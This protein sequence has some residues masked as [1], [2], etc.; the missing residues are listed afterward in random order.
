MHVIIIITFYLIKQYNA[1]MCLPLKTEYPL[2]TITNRTG[3]ASA[4][5]TM[6]ALPRTI[7]TAI[8][9]QI[10]TSAKLIAGILDVVLWSVRR[11]GC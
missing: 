8:S 5:I 6:T 4:I 9:Q 11:W 10:L 7:A 1:G 3:K 2:P